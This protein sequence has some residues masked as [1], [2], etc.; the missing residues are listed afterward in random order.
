MRTRAQGLSNRQAEILDYI[1][2]QINLKGYPPSVR[3]IGEAVGLQSSSTVHNHLTQLEQ[4]GYIRRDP[5]KPRAIMILKTNDEMEAFYEEDTPFDEMINVPIIGC[6]AAGTPILASQ[7]VE[8]TITFPM[9]LIRNNNSFMLKVKGD[10]MINVGI[11]DGDLLI[12]SPQKVANNGDIVVA[13]IGEEATVKTFYREKGRIRLQP[14]NDAMEPIYATDVELAG[15]VTGLF[16]NM[17]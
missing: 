1:V 6:V 2:K 12:V 14:E 10:S 4:K 9:H 16:R 7:N 11:Y 5:T 17:H 13:L 8:D 15:K 3:E